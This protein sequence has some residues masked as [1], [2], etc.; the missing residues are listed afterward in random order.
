MI[1]NGKV[2]AGSASAEDLFQQAIP[3]DYRAQQTMQIAE[4]V[5]QG[6]RTSLLTALVFRLGREWLAV[7]AALCQQILSPVESHTLPHRSNSTLL[8]VVNVQGRL[9]LKVSLSDALGLSGKSEAEVTA[10]S[11]EQPMPKRSVPRQPMLKPLMSKQSV[12]KQPMFKGYRRMIVMEKASPQ[13]MR[14]EPAET[15]VFEVDE[16]YGVHSLANEDLQTV[17][18]G[19]SAADTVCTRCIFAWNDQQVGLLDEDKL[20]ETLRQRAL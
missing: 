3:A 4:V 15:W 11:S 14:N 16:L 12:P 20:F 19:V 2:R 17:M 7:P 18:V 5:T 13:G 8:G 6:D 9:L 1:L 10:R